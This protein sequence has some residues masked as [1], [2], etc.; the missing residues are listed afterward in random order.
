M[1]LCLLAVLALLMAHYAA[2]AA[3]VTGKNDWC[4]VS[5]SGA[6]FCDYKSYNVCADANGVVACTYNPKRKATQTH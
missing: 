2:S 1:R 3:T 6:L 4:F 5:P